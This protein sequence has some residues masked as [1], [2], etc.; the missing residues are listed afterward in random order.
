MRQKGTGDLVEGKR[1]PRLQLG[2]AMMVA[3]VAV[4]CVLVISALMSGI[5]E[6]VADV[7]IFVATLVT[8][9][10]LAYRDRDPGR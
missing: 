9:R 7:V 6:S 10:R 8:L 2:E 1:S 4:G 5:A 3:G